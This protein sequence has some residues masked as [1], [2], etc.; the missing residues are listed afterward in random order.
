MLI[1]IQARSVLSTSTESRNGTTPQRTEWAV[2]IH[3]AGKQVRRDVSLKDPLTRGQRKV[4]RWYLEEYLQ[5]SPYSADIEKQARRLLEEYPK[6]LWRNLCLTKM[7][8][9]YDSTPQESLRLCTIRVT[10][11]ESVSKDSRHTI[12]QLFWET[13]EYIDEGAASGWKVTIERQFLPIERSGFPLR[14]QMGNTRRIN[15]LLVIGR[16]TTRNSKKYDDVSPLLAFKAVSQV[17]KSLNSSGSPLKIHLEVARPGTFASFEGHLRRTKE[18]HGPG[19]FQIVHFDL[20]GAVKRWGRKDE[21]KTKAGIL[22]FTCGDSNKTRPVLALKVATVLRQYDIPLVILNACNSAAA[23]FGDDANIAGVLQKKGGVRNVLAMSFRIS[24]ATAELFL[25]RFYFFFLIGGLTLS[26]SSREARRSLRLNTL[27]PARFGLE[28]ELLDAFVPV[29]Y[30]PGNICALA[31]DESLGESCLKYDVPYRSVS[32]TLHLPSNIVGRDFDIL[33][34]EKALCQDSIIYLHGPTGVG[35]TSLLQYASALWQHTHW[36][37][38]V[39]TINFGAEKISSAADFANAALNQLL[40]AYDSAARS[41]LWI[42][43]SLRTQSHDLE[44]VKDI[45]REVISTCKVVFIVDGLDIL[46]S[47]SHVIAGTSCF[48]SGYLDIFE[49]IKSIIIPSTLCSTESRSWLIVAARHPNV[50]WIRR[51]LGPVSE[52]YCLKLQELDLADSMELSQKVLSDAGED[53]SKWD[54]PDFDWLVA[55]I[56]LLQGIPLALKEILPIQQKLSIPWREFYSELHGDL[57]PS[58][59]GLVFDESESYSVLKEIVLICETFPRHVFVLLSLL[60][61]YWGESAPVHCLWR[62]FMAATREETKDEEQI[63]PEPE[64]FIA[65]F[66]PILSFAFHRGYIY[67]E[68]GSH[69]TSFQVHPLFT[70]Y[71]RTLVPHMN[72]HLKHPWMRELILKSIQLKQLEEQ[73]LADSSNESFAERTTLNDEANLLTSIRLCLELSHIIPAFEWPTHTLYIYLSDH[74][75]PI[76]LADSYL[77]FLKLCIEPFHISGDKWP[78]LEF[79]VLMISHIYG[80]PQLCLWLRERCQEVT[81][82]LLEFMRILDEY[83]EKDPSLQTM[84]VKAILFVILLQYQSVFDPDISTIDSTSMA[85]VILNDI[86]VYRQTQ[87]L[88]EEYLGQELDTIIR[89]IEDIKSSKSSSPPEEDVGMPRWKAILAGIPDRYAETELEESSSFSLVDL[90]LDVPEKK[91]ALFMS[92]QSLEEANDTGDWLDSV[93]YH[94]SLLEGAIA[95][96]SYDEAGQHL[97]AIRRICKTAGCEG[98]LSDF[99][100][101]NKDI[102]DLR[103]QFQFLLSTCPSSEGKRLRDGIGVQKEVVSARADRTPLLSFVTNYQLDKIA[104]E[105]GSDGYLPGPSREEMIRL[106]RKHTKNRTCAEMEAQ[107]ENFLEIWMLARQAMAETQY[108]SCLKHLDCIEKMLEKSEY[109]RDCFDVVEQTKT[110]RQKCHEGQPLVDQLYAQADA[111]LTGDFDR[112]R[113]ILDGI[114]DPD[115]RSSERFPALYHALD[116]EHLARELMDARKLQDFSRVRELHSKYTS[117]WYDPKNKLSCIEEIQ[118]AIAENLEWLLQRSH[119]GKQWQVG[120]ELCEEGLKYCDA[121]DEET[122]F[123]R[124]QLCKSREDFEVGLVLESLDAAEAA[125]DLSACLESFNS[126]ARIRSNQTQTIVLGRKDYI[127]LSDKQMEFLRWC[128]EDGCIPC[129]RWSRCREIQPCTFEEQKDQQYQKERHDRSLFRAPFGCLHRS[130]CVEGFC[131]L[132]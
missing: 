87:D 4:C 53:I 37:D 104:A 48:D 21:E 98:P 96:F 112:A 61:S 47:P 6:R 28:R 80:N 31:E 16:D 70:I 108:S 34:L 85:E 46:S 79:C 76:N 116:L 63:S 59:G 29:L 95:N 5:T 129:A 119:D 69:A 38:A 90:E 25:T 86:I 22:Y 81:H 45:L 57:S 54:Y 105:Q 60:S 66:V 84:L 114:S 128:Y 65:C 56:G 43:P 14:E 106:I 9:L 122:S 115:L 32:P 49:L 23:Y 55:C 75:L 26:A 27:R 102:N 71:A 99:E 103:A 126:L 13:L 68:S 39:V 11:S 51:A 20:H 64:D 52:P 94:R 92:L 113:S 42:I 91:D 111:V 130:Q 74:R 120:I 97:F 62:L 18:K 83:N 78:T 19:Y 15:V 7:L 58:L 121:R 35:K 82:L 72:P 88:P 127:M 117:I 1:E 10:E 3:V 24:S 50:E 77:D 93:H 44:A 123:E 89:T 17:Q 125:E 8:S 67:S 40:Q 132:G 41:G 100:R 36:A 131:F 124:A 109:L 33:R 73:G 110:I 2:H 30:G 107:V 12:H 101:M 118:D